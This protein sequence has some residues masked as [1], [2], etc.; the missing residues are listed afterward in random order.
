MQGSLGEKIGEGAFAD[1]HA[2]A[3]GQ[4]V[5]LFKA[6]AARR[7]SRREVRMTRAVFAAGAPAPEVFGEVELE[8]RLGIVL[9]R[10]DGPTLLQPT[11]SGAMTRD[12][13]GAILA[14]LCRSVHE[15]PPPSD[16]PFLR[17]LMEGWLRIPGDAV[18]N[19]SPSASSP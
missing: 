9:S 6:G 5:K 1:V 2:W 8:G 15:T 11:R 17:D 12:Q 18:P 16:V 4:V 3:P 10:F 19:T 14:S 7:F 13:A